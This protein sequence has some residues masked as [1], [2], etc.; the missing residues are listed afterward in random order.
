L[1]GS[2]EWC[3][4]LRGGPYLLRCF[5]LC[6]PTGGARLARRRLQEWRLL[7]GAAHQRASACR[8]CGARR[9][10]TL[11]F[12]VGCAQI[13]C[14]PCAGVQPF[15][16]CELQRCVRC[17]AGALPLELMREAMAALSKRTRA[18]TQDSHLRAL[19][20]Y[21]AWAGGCVEG[22]CLPAEPVEVLLYVMYCL[23]R[24][25]PTLDRTRW[26]KDQSRWQ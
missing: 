26:Q 10:T 25:V 7:V 5:R 8:R 11:V 15:A 24:R 12:C 4:G 9:S 13:L 14:P 22:C 2:V 19:R 1:G 18:S 20:A 3:G 21:R 17:M 16:L 23:E 6:C